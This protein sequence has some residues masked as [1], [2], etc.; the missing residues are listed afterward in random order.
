M[1]F[2]LMRSVLRDINISP[3]FCNL[4]MFCRTV[5]DPFL[6]LIWIIVSAQF[7]TWELVEIIFLEFL[8]FFPSVNFFFSHE[9]WTKWKN[10]RRKVEKNYRKMI[11]LF[12][13]CGKE[14][15]QKSFAGRNFVF[16]RLIFLFVTHYIVKKKNFVLLPK[17]FFSKHELKK[18]LP[19]T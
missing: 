5:I 8:N 10:F 4:W 15:N 12:F 11:I 17:K 16:V 13:V 3:C 19:K 6:S 9:C 18:I 1:F 14:F 7:M 2:Q